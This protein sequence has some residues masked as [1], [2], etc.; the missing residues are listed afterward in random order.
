[1]DLDDEELEATRR[2]NGV[3]KMSDIEKD[4]KR[5]EQ[6]IKP[7][8]A[9]WIGISNQLAIA[10][11]VDKVK[12]LEIRQKEM[13]EEYCPKTKEI[14]ELKEELFISNYLVENSI[15]KQE[16]EDK[17]EKLKINSQQIYKEFLKSNRLDMDLHCRGIYTD[18]QIVIL[19][20]LLE[21][22]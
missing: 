13:C 8:H 15:S 17:I 7:E 10:H 5:C 16:I 2:L 21:E 1:M 18:A 3:A 22:K 11:I 19:K 4:I 6:L 12:E 14:K 20:E 9:N